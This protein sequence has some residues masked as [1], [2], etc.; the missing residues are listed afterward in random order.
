MTN[1][2]TIYS[3]NIILYSIIFI[4]IFESLGQ[5]CLKKSQKNHHLFAIG[6]ISY[7]IVCLLLCVCYKHDGFIGKVN[8]MWSCMSI[9]FVI[10]VGYIFLQEKIER[11]DIIALLLALLAIYFANK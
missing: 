1:I 10:L 4:T 2:E 9:V 6:L 7:L 8:L 3:N 5:L 11:H